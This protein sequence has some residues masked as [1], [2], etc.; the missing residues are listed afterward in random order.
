MKRIYFLVAFAFISITSFAQ[1]YFGY[2][3]IAKDSIMV[4]GCTAFH[5][6]SIPPIAAMIKNCQPQKQLSIG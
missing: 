6:L 4:N 3:L 1:T 5:L 2:R